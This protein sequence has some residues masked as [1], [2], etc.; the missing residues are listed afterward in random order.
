MNQEDYT[1]FRGGKLTKEHAMR[2]MI[3]TI[4][5]GLYTYMVMLEN[6]DRVGEAAFYKDIRTRVFDIRAHIQH[7]VTAA[8][9]ERL[10]NEMRCIYAELETARVFLSAHKPNEVCILQSVT[11]DACGLIYTIKHFRDEE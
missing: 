4:G 2:S 10:S 3:T 1:A 11:N 6:A 7:D 9:L 5:G 8:V